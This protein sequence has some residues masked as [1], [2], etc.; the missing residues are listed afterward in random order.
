LRYVHVDVFTQSRA[1]GAFGE[2]ARR[3]TQLCG[4]MLGTSFAGRQNGALDREP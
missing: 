3:D 2:G 4:R 1:P